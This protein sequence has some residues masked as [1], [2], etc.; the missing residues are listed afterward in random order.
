MPGK[1]LLRTDVEA[2]Y[3]HVYNRGV[4]K[5]R[6]FCDD[7]DYRFFSSL[8]AR[9]IGPNVVRDK[10]GRPYMHMK[11]EVEII[12]FCWMPNHF[13][14]LVYQ[15]QEGALRELL[16]RACTAYTMYFN[17]KY[18][19]RG[20]LYESN[21]KASIVLSDGYLQHIS[22]YIHLNP[23]YYREWRFSSY[24]TFTGEVQSPEW[25]SYERLF[26]NIPIER[27]DYAAF[28]SDYEANKR[29]I[30]DLKHQLADH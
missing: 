19:R 13:H 30:D 28:V 22:R 17:K 29:A 10:M 12:S 16:S 23:R 8:F 24:Q 21:Y 25:L 4:N 2:S 9:H 1:N 18:G 6:I 11:G 27:A 3:Y 26:E 15:V 14:L 20:P 7:E 5:R